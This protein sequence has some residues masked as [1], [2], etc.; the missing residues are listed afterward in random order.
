MAWASPLMVLV[1][2]PD[3]PAERRPSS[4]A[5][6]N[7]AGVTSPPR[8]SSTRAVIASAAFTD[9]CWPMIDPTREWKGSSDARDPLPIVHS[10]EVS[11]ISAKAGSTW[12][13]CWAAFFILAA[14]YATRA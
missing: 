14:E 1:L 13:R 4:S 6:T 2:A 10:G 8:C 11:T 7:R 5:K 3:S 9:T 12:T